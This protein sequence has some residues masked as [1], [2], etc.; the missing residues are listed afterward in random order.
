MDEVSKARVIYTHWKTVTRK[1]VPL[2]GEGKAKE[3]PGHGE[4]G[5]VPRYRKP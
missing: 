2:G 1:Q 4:L 3:R 5:L